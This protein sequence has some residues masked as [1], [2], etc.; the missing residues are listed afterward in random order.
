MIYLHDET[1]LISNMNTGI[2][3]EYGVAYH[4]MPSTQKAIFLNHVI[5]KHKK[6]NKILEAIENIDISIKDI[7][8]EWYNRNGFYVS[9]L[10]TQDDM[11]G[12]P[13]DIL[14][15]SNGEINHGI[16]IK[17]NNKN[18][19]SPSGKHFLSDEQIEYLYSEYKTKYIP[20]YISHM[21]YIYGRCRYLKNGHRTSWN[22][23][24]CV[25]T[26]I[27][28]DRIRDEVIKSWNGKKIKDKLEIIKLGYHEETD[29]NCSIITLKR[30]GTYK[31]EKMQ[32]IPK[33]ISDIKLEK[34][35]TSQ[36]E[37]KANGSSIGKMQVKPNGGFIQRNGKKNPFMV[38]ECN[39]G[40]GDLFGSW[41]FGV[42]KILK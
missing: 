42:V 31:L 32:M 14:L 27:F 8:S 37:F 24:R 30:N 17:F 34:C 39:Y 13:S 11:L 28:I 29:I 20:I 22:R 21:E 9:L 3:Y 25:V 35:N 10:P 7:A 19:W 26:D 12:G 5:H 15:C 1:K 18:T 23:K 4:L 38:G 40:E 2:E 36:L 41:N 16:S 6:K 33:N